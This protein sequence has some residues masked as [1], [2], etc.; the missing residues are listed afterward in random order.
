MGIQTMTR[1]R[2][3]KLTDDRLNETCGKLL[4]FLRKR[5][6]LSIVD[7]ANQMGV[8]TTHLN[9]LETGRYAT[10]LAVLQKLCTIYGVTLVQFVTHLE[11]QMKEKKD[12]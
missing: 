4:R 10:R 2:A 7:V 11:K 9:D 3:V 5:K 6:A 1:P 8:S 12:E